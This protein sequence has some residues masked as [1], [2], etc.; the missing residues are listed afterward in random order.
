[1]FAYSDIRAEL[2]RRITCLL[3]DW[4]PLVQKNK[5]RIALQGS[6]SRN[7]QH[8]TD[9]DMPIYCKLPAD[10]LVLK[11]A[12]LQAAIA[13]YYTALHRMIRNQMTGGTILINTECGVDKRY[14]PGVH[15]SPDGAVQNYDEKKLRTRLDEMVSTGLLTRQQYRDIYDGHADR[16]LIDRAIHLCD[17]LNPHYF[18]T[19]SFNEALRGTKTMSDGREVQMCDSMLDTRILVTCVLMLSSNRPVMVDIII[20]LSLI[21][22]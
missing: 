10:P 12:E 11:P 20:Y 7:K 1:M 15:I 2:E 3:S 8:M 5:C 21:H 13:P 17:A 6:F 19:W 16:S 18:L 22:I 4:Q 9:I 14:C